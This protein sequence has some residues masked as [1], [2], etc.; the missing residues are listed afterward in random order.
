MQKANRRKIISSKAGELG[1]IDVHHL[2][3]D[4]IRNQHKKVVFSM[5]GGWVQQS[6]MGRGGGGYKVAHG[7]VLR[8]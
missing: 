1:H 2:N 6:G 4:I 8:A 5:C 3:K 7:D